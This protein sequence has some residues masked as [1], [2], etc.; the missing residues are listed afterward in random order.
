MEENNKAK[1]LSLKMADLFDG[2]TAGEVLHALELTTISVINTIDDQPL[3]QIVVCG[4]LINS[5]SE[6]MTEIGMKKI[7]KKNNTHSK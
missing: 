4:H 2:Y 6:V 1:E 5:I 3:K 7:I